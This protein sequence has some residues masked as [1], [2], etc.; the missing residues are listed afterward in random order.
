MIDFPDIYFTPEY[1]RLYARHEGGSLETFSFKTGQG[2]VY[3]QFIKRPLEG[4]EGYEQYSDIVTP[5]GYG[6]PIFI[7]TEEKEKPELAAAFGIAFRAYCMEQKIVSAFVRFHPVLNN[8]P[9]FRGVFDEVV[10]IRKTIAIDL[11]KNLFKDEFDYVIKKNCRKA[12]R[13]GLSIQYD[14]RLETLEKFVQLYYQLMGK[15]NA[16]GYYFFP[17]S[18]FYELKNIGNAVELVNAVLDGEIVAAIMYFKYGAFIHTHL[19]GTTEE[20]Y[21]TRAAEFIKSNRA[22]LAKDEGY[23]WCHLGGGFS[24]DPD[25]SLLRFKEKFS[26]TPPFDFC[27]GKSVY[28]PAAYAA[29]CALADDR[30]KLSDDTFFPLYRGYV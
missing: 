25:D 5:Y 24:N 20:G 6:G 9:D 10:P 11:T 3:F 30:K 22:L 27:I 23:K 19:S 26:K 28:D 7:N 8:A 18:Y 13:Y 2:E 12:E 29:L 17:E 14:A 15:K 1:G 21:R 4:F 16:I